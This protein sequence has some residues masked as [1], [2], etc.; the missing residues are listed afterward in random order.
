MSDE[1]NG[2]KPSDAKPSPAPSEAK[3]NP[4]LSEIPVGPV[5]PEKPLVRRLFVGARLSVATSNSLARA[6]EQLARRAKDAGIDLRFVAPPS[7]HV[8]LKF[9]GWARTEVIDAIRD[10]LAEAGQ[11]IAPFKLKAAKLGG[12]PS[13]EKATVLW[14]GVEEPSGA[15]AQ[16]AARIETAM[17]EIGFAAEPRAFHPHIT[18]ARARETR[19]LQQVVLPIAEQMFG[20]SVVD[21]ITLF[22]SETKSGG[23]AYRDVARI[24]LGKPETGAI[25]TA[26][27]QTSPVDL[28]A[29]NELGRAGDEDTDDGWP[30]GQGPT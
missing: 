7:Y 13:I 25:R 8:T 20:D 2:P 30:R 1:T 22:E 3:P 17:V 11:G 5:P 10:K 26:E 28:S 24:D 27:R 9:L 18:L 14:A 16:L 12:F 23:S 29:P 4:A 19:S 15:F 21:A 6:A